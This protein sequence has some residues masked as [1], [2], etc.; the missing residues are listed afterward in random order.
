MWRDWR[1]LRRRA[2]GD[3][4]SGAPPG[5]GAARTVPVRAIAGEREAKARRR[6]CRELADRGKAGGGRLVA[7]EQ[8]YGAFASAHA[9]HTGEKAAEA[10]R[11]KA[12]GNRLQY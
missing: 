6:A 11:A 3:H 8:E 1:R 4:C 12:A 5:G 10:Q 7:R 9:A 2:F